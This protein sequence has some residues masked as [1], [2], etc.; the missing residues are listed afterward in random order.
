MSQAGSGEIKIGASVMTM[1]G[2]MYQGFNMEPP[3]GISSSYGSHITAEDSALFKAFS[4]GQR[5]LKAIAVHVKHLIV[6]K[7]DSNANGSSVN[8]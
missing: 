8:H 4:D 3:L 7:D 6:N 2:N 1:N 5:E